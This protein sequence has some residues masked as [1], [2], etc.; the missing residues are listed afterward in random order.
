VTFAAV[1]AIIGTRFADTLSRYFWSTVIALVAGGSIIAVIH[2]VLVQGQVDHRK[3]TIERVSQQL[4][5]IL[6]TSGSVKTSVLKNRLD[7]SCRPYFDAAIKA[8]REKRH[9]T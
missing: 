5:E 2:M 8:L 4:V 9:I 3:A 7:K 1:V 6:E